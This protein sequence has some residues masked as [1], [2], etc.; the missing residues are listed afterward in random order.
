MHEHDLYGC[1]ATKV[2]LGQ[3]LTLSQETNPIP[4]H[5]KAQHDALDE[6]FAAV[7]YDGGLPFSLFESPAM[8][9]ALPWLNPSYKPPSK[10]LPP[11]STKLIP[12]W[13]TKYLN[14]LPELN[15]TTDESSDINKA[16]ITN[17]TI[18]TFISSI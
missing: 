16:R 8:K 6:D 7:C 13:K 1:A 17:V 10:Q 9:G 14:S 3:H 15:V 5:S 18:Y 4:Y 11:P 2:K 12:K